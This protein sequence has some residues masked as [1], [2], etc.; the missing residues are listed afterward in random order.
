MNI[1]LI[2]SL[3]IDEEIKQ[4]FAPDI[5]YVEQFLADRGILVN[6]S[7]AYMFYNHLFAFLDRIS[8]GECSQTLEEEDLEDQLTDEARAL[9]KE[10]S[11]PL[12]SKYG[13]VSSPCEEVL[14]ATYFVM[15]SEQRTNESDPVNPIN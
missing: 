7:V 8:R 5:A 6:E 15:F 2:R 1:E 12:F 10:L 3:P 4:K 11:S 14:L 13:I 9:A